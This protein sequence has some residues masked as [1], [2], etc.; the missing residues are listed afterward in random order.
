MNYNRHDPAKN[1]DRHIFRSDRILQS[2]ELNEL[3]SNVF[4]RLAELG[5]VL[6][7]DGDLVRDCA[8]LVDGI[9]GAVQLHAGALY[10]AGAVRGIGPAE[11]TI[12]VVGSVVIGVYLQ[13]ATV[14]EL[15]DP[16]LL[17]PAVGTRG[18]MEPGAARLRITP[19][20]GVAGDGKDGPFYPVYEVVDG[21]LKAKDAP[22][23]IDA[24]AVAIQKYDREST[25]GSYIVGGLNV[26]RGAEF[27][28]DRQ[29]Y[30]IGAGSARVNGRAVTL[31]GALRHV[32]NAAPD[33]A[34]IADEPHLSSGP[35][36]QRITFDFAPVASLD[37]V[38][39]TAERTVTL[40]H[41][42]VSGAL[43]P[44][45]DT[46]VLKLV[47]VSQGGIIYDHQGADCKLTAGKVDWSPSG[48]EPAA[49]S[50]YQVTYQHIVTVAP[51]DID[52]TGFTVE[53][54]VA[55]SLVLVSY[56]YKVPRVDRLCLDTAGDIVAL[57]GVASDWMPV[58]P[59][60]PGN[61]LL[62]ATVYQRWNAGSWLSQDA[63][64][65]VPM[66]DLAAVQKQ[67]DA[68]KVLIAS[69]ALRTDAANREAVLKRSMFVDPLL[70]DSMRD[71]GTAQS[72]AIVAGAL[73]LPVTLAA[74]YFGNDVAGPA[75]LA[76][77]LVPLIEQP[78]RT[79]SMLVNPYQSFAPIPAKVTLTPAI[80]Q[81]TY[82]A[83][84]WTSTMTTRI[85]QR[86][87]YGASAGPASTEAIETVSSSRADSQVIQP[88]TLTFSITGF[89]AGETLV[90]AS[91]DGIAIEPGTLDDPDARPVA[92]AAGDLS[93][94][95]T[96]PSNIAAGRKIVQFIGAAGSFGSA[97][98]TGAS[99]IEDRVLRR[100]VTEYAYEYDPPPA[101]VEPV[102]VPQTEV[103]SSDYI[104]PLPL[105]EPDADATRQM[106]N[107]MYRT[108]LGRNAEPD[109][110]N[111]WT[112]RV[113]EGLVG[114]DL[115]ETFLLA[116]TLREREAAEGG[117]SVWQDIQDSYARHGIA[118][119]GAD[120][121]AQTIV[122]PR[123]AHLAGVDL[124]FTA[125]GESDVL[126]HLRA[127]ATGIPTQ[128]ILAQARLKPSQIHTDG[129]T[130]VL[131]DVPYFAP[132][133]EELAIVTMCN[134]AETALAIAELGKFDGS[135]WITA[136]PYTIGVLLSSSNNSTWTAH[137]DRDLRFR[138]LA[139]TYTE[140]VRT[141]DLG[142]IE[143]EGATD[144]MVLGTQQTPGGY[145][146]IGYTLTLPDGTHIKA[147]S[148]Q[149]LALPAP[150]T[151][152]IGIAATLRGD[153][154][155]SPVLHPGGQLL[156]GWLGAQGDYV[157][158][159][160]A[161]G[162]DSRVR[163]VVEALLPSGATFDVALRGQGGAW[164]DPI[165]QI[166]A[167]PADDGWVELT[168][169]Q[170]GID[171]ATVQARLLQ[172]GSA[173]ARPFVRSVRMMVM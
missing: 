27:A 46:A 113:E 168:Y 17:N 116:A 126:V 144:L 148:N 124:W 73:S 156:V 155:A 23:T 167:R 7:K 3:Q 161:A 114:T 97:Y 84:T 92:D 106:V 31:K 173:A 71:A 94:R 164:S 159:A 157:S 38:G 39:I 100:V 102:Y 67:L 77:T 54:A 75:T 25:G 41:G 138:L 81:M 135:D 63:P 95:I 86:V 172:T 166:A 129:P 105:Q 65:M 1:Y 107:E 40:T 90:G 28:G 68:L 69:Q 58:P 139:A 171:D 59:S 112:E 109:G 8:C 137:Q 12:P 88:Q 32:F 99:W 26:Q 70:D 66:A 152:P 120:P 9:I 61:L 111:Y 49:G 87:A 154:A 134:D 165:P 96:I 149:P 110:L 140:A 64:R 160:I 57:K 47:S 101:P 16:S 147:A 22:P 119:T 142:S 33:L 14:T 85:V 151:G 169:E 93:G 132:P 60:V 121:L 13:E 78:R 128:T 4:G 43:D 2:A 55:E 98:F 44:L 53:G 24:V 125:V 42:V 89:Q 76:H 74:G 19:V 15:D 45:P 150:I 145:S 62:L 37:K 104:P 79:S 108:Y 48:A 143:V 18:Y 29:T 127:T 50:S 136:Q 91:F 20:W 131:F 21:V 56:R 141:I 163:V 34:A 35:G 103:P 115:V 80:D 133:E 72:G 11:F 83:D 5:N 6:F 36:A 10:L 117:R 162:P 158:R 146:A 30:L 170:S 122:V 82:T 52:D 118:Y 51:T 123:A 153:A 130:R